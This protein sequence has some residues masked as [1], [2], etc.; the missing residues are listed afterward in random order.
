[1]EECNIFIRETLN[2]LPSYWF[3]LYQ[4]HKIVLS[5]LDTKKMN[6]LWN[7]FSEESDGKKKMHL[8]NLNNV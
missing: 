1:M 4:I 2:S 6:F 7:E 8:I 3:V 5:I